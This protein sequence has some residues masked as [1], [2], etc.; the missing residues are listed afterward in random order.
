MRRSL[1]QQRARERLAGLMLIAAAGAA[2][3]ATNSPLADAY[4]SLV[5][6][7]LGVTLPRIGELDIHGLVVDG[8]MAVFFLLVGLEVKREWFAG[9]LASRE[10]RRLPIIAAVAGMAVPALIY[11]AVAWNQPQ[12]NRG[13]AVPTAT[14]I[15]FAVAVLAILGSRAPPSIKV[16]LIAV[17]IVD[18]IGAVALIALFYTDSLDVPALATAL[19]LVAGLATANLLGVRRRLFYLA[20][21]LVLWWFVLKSGIHPTIA[22]VLAGATVPLDKGERHSTLERLEHDLHPLVMFAIVP[23]FG[24]V[25]AGVALGG[26]GASLLTPLPLAIALG[27]FVGKQAGVFGAVR[28]AAAAGLCS[29]P[30]G[31]SWMQI[32]GAALLTGIGFTMSLF[33]ADLAFDSAAELEAAK[34]GVLAGS[35]LAAL[36][37]W[38]VLRIAPQ[39]HTSAGHD[40][41][42]AERIFGQHEGPDEAEDTT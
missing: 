10:A 37:G 3:V 29:K 19:G 34:L 21:F 16:L 28:L 38:L 20:G 17:A 25:S 33:I 42:E 24:F 5:H 40:I 35:L 6:F 13:W 18:D 9:Q 12:L 15:A 2:L 27:L 4:H 26:G 14:D 11:L 23:L 39:Q 1:E 22:G 8:L 30:A 36:A 31:A 32:Y 7:K 41:D